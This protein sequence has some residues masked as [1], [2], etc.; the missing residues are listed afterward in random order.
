VLAGG[1]AHD[2]NNLLVG[3]LG[4]AGI[5]LD[6]LPP[7][8]PILPIVEDIETAAKRAA[9]LTKQMLA[10][11]GKGRFIIER[12]NVNRIVDEM[13]HLLKSVISSTATLKI[14]Y[15]DDLP[16]VEGDA[17]QLRQVVMNLI[18]NASDAMQ[19][20]CGVIAVSTGVID[21]DGAYL[22]STYLD[23]DLPSGRYVYIEVSDTGRGMD[24]TTRERIFDP[25][26]TTKF[27]G[28]GLGLAAVLGI[29]RGHKGAIKVYSEPTRG[30]TFKILLPQTVRAGPSLPRVQRSQVDFRQLSGT[31]LVADD[32]PSVRAVARRILER[33]G[34][35]VIDCADGQEALEAFATHHATIDAVL[36]DLTMPRLSGDQA[37]R[38]M[39]LIDPN[40]RVVLSSGYNSEDAN[41][42]F[43]GKG[44]AGFLQKPYSPSQLLAVIRELFEGSST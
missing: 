38:E 7:E 15:C 2:F 23:D 11:S 28:R 32:E 3:V 14:N 35:R 39:R 30:S 19:G 13:S 9:E 40:V 20:E 4:N 12:L 24:A 29:L 1:I 31:I 37:F 27:T 26:F 33:S 21:A 10:Y 41:T 42:G 43:S 44:L 6:A 17:T 36:L 5:L 22:A 25:F 16:E 18:T 8:S 34:L